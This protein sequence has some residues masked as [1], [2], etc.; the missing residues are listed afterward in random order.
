MDVTALV[1]SAAVR[2]SLPGS[3]RTW[4]LPPAPSATMTVPV[5]T[6]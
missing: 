2:T 5:G 4:S 6:S 3:R 1:P